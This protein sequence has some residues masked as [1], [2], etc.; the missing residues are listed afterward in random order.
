[1]LTTTTII[2]NCILSSEVP[3]NH[4]PSS[5][6]LRPSRLRHGCLACIVQ[7]PG[8]EHGALVLGEHSPVIL[9]TSGIFWLSLQ[10]F[11]FA[12]FWPWFMLTNDGQTIVNNGSPM[13][14]DGISGHLWLLPTD[15]SGAN[16]GVLCDARWLWSQWAGSRTTLQ[17]S[18]W[19]RQATRNNES[20]KKVVLWGMSRP[21]HQYLGRQWLTSLIG[22]F[23]QSY[24]LNSKFNHPL[25]L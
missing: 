4:R 17:W 2:N 8:A 21:T 11:Q 1:M 24:W 16:M 7:E 19:S 3:E 22:G 6:K 9:G 20:K 5:D 25:V 12:A 13:V 14:D 23:I 10:S 15:S 18:T